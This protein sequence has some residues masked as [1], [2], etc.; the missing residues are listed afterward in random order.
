MYCFFPVLKNNL[1]LL[2]IT[3]LSAALRR[4]FFTFVTNV[5]G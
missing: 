5:P 2:N 4:K 1:N 3:Q